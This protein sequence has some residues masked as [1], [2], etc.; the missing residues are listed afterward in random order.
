[1]ITPEGDYLSNLTAPDL[2]PYFKHL[3]WRKMGHSMGHLVASDWAD[4]AVYDPVFGLYKN[5]G[6]WTRDE[7]AILHNVVESLP[8]GDWL[9]IGC[10]TGWTSWHIQRAKNNYVHYCD[11]CGFIFRERIME[12][13][14][15][16]HGIPG[17]PLSMTSNEYFA[18]ERMFFFNFGG[19]QCIRMRDS[20]GEWFHGCFTWKEG[21]GFTKYNPDFTP[22]FQGVVIDGDHE[23]GKPLEDAI[24]AHSVLADTG[25]IMFHDFIG[26]P[27]R[28][29]VTW[30]MDHHPDC[31]SFGGPAYEC[32]CGRGFKAR[33]YWTPHM[34]AC[35]W[36]GDFTP[37]DHVGDP[38]INWAPHIHQMKKD[39]DFRRLS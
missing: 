8:Q 14:E 15:S 9:D 21:K 24:N 11:P 25:V 30:L 27:V 36:R 32:D 38:R 5:C 39:F 13:S 33:V 17:V 26:A 2:R 19:Q 6:L 1:M 4:K 7:A 12:N 3:H 18:S 23:P 16:G 31:A 35:C 34:V 28:E 20:S 37:P 10:H 29:A 22:T